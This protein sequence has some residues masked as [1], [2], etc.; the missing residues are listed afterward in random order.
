MGYVGLWAKVVPIVVMVALMI[1]AGWWA[2]GTSGIPL[3]NAAGATLK[4]SGSAHLI[5]TEGVNIPSIPPSVAYTLD[6]CTNHLYA[7]NVLPTDC[8]GTRPT[9]VAYDSGKGEVFVANS[10]SNSVSVI[11]DSSNTVVATVTVGTSPWGLAYD[12]GKG[13]VFVTNWGSDNVSVISDSSNTVVTTVTVGSH[14]YGGAYDSGKGEVFVANY[15]SGNVSAISDSNNTVVATMTVGSYPIGMAYDSGKG[16]VFVA[17][18]GSSNVSVI[19]DS[20]NTVVATVIIG[21]NPYGVAYDNG[22]VLVTL[23]KLNNV[24]LISDATNKEVSFIAVGSAPYG[25]WC[26][27]GTGGIYVTN[28]GTGTVSVIWATYVVTFAESGL[29]SG[30]DWSVTLGGDAHENTTQTIQFT[31]PSGTYNFSVGSVPGYTA[32]PSTGSL[33]VNGS[34]VTMSI[35]FTIPPAATYS[36]SFHEAGLPTGTKWSV[37]LNGTAQTSTTTVVIFAEPNGTYSYAIAKVGS[38][39]PNPPSGSVRVNGV[40]VSQLISFSNTT[41]P[42]YSCPIYTS[43]VLGSPPTLEA[44]DNAKG[45]VFVTNWNAG[46]VN[47]ISDSSNAIVATVSVGSWPDA[48]AFDSGAGEVF[49]AN[50]ASGTVSVISGADNS[51]VGTIPVGS[52]PWALSYDSGKGEI[53]VANANS[54]VVSVISDKT[55]Q[56]VASIQIGACDPTGMTYDSVKG[57]IFADDGSVIADSNNT[58]VATVSW[59]TSFDGG[60]IGVT[61][62]YGKDEFFVADVNSDNVSVV[63][64]VTN[65]VTASVPLGGSPEGLAYDGGKA[66][67]FVA[68]SDCASLSCHQG[69]VSVISEA[70]NKVTATVPLKSS[71]SS[72]VSIPYDVVYDSGKGEIFVTFTGSEDVII[73]S[74]ANNRVVSIG[75]GGGQPTSKA[76]TPGF[77][78]L[79]GSEGYILI[80]VVIAVVAVVAAL[81]LKRRPS[82]PPQAKSVPKEGPEGD[83]EVEKGK[84]E[85]EG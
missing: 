70:T 66:E 74:D 45:E 58:V 6:L 55:N 69:N 60:G 3:Q 11:S 4:S 34:N 25:V 13:E 1:P 61:Y 72:L 40:N 10:G 22:K 26:D 67:I 41:R 5:E 80:G 52:N 85:R 32:T 63:S 53:F 35:A 28:Y 64:D 31:V 51:V 59:G 36:L 15:G 39:V 82:S 17:N 68:D 14:P 83:K 50:Y 44:Y 77:L 56:V 12:S 79:A 23:P 38:Y 24:T 18:W 9:G 49:V 21:A 65:A 7:G 47:V 2:S 46:S 48:I 76:Q 75:G 71:S 37:T 30:V 16:E 20:S 62:D 42:K 33:V 19:S 57:E 81:L 27:G 8:G 54:T 78:G 29:P 73:I 43:L 84:A